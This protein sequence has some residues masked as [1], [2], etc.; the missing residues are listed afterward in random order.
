MLKIP[1]FNWT[2]SLKHD[3]RSANYYL[4]TVYTNTIEG[5]GEGVNKVSLDSINPACE[6]T[7]SPTVHLKTEIQDPT[8]KICNSLHT[9]NNDIVLCAQ[10][11]STI[12]VFDTINKIGRCNVII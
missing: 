10:M 9:T 1:F 2:K 12:L 4:I 11:K 5:G 7:S 6:K 8:T 3:T